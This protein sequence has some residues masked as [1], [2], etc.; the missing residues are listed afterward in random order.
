M[1][2]VNHNGHNHP[3]KYGGLGLRC[4][5]VVF[6]LVNRVSLIF[7]W[8]YFESNS[9]AFGINSVDFGINSVDFGISSF[10]FQINS[11]DFSNNSDDFG[12]N[13][14]DLK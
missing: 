4:R 14:V 10:E 3:A 13:S 5:K 8:I 1:K 12:V 2:L 11:V 6:S 7:K 9:V